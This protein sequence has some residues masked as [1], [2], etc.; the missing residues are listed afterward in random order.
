MKNKVLTISIIMAS[1][2]TVFSWIFFDQIVVWLIDF[3]NQLHKPMASWTVSKTIFALSIGIIPMLSFI[4]WIKSVKKTMG[5]FVAY[6]SIVWCMAFLIIIIT[7]LLLDGYVKS[8]SPWLPDYMVW[9]PFPSFWNYALPFAI[10]LT[11]A[12]LFIVKISR[13]ETHNRVGD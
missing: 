12:I 13:N 9:L 1:V 7:F 4:V 10:V 11:P 2:L 6:N 8:E 3:L 5:L